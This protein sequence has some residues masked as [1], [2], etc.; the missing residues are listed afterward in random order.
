MLGEE[1]EVMSI[2]SIA[3]AERDRY[4]AYFDASLAEARSQNPESASELLIAINNE[5][6]PYPY[7]YLRVDLIG[8]LPDGSDRVY[9]LWLDPAPDAEGRGF[10][11]GPVKIEMY[12]FTWCS[13]QLAFDRPLPDM[14]KLE[15]LLTQLLDID[16]SRSNSGTALANA[17]HSVSQIETNGELW[18]LTIDFGTAPVD[19]LLDLIDFLMA[20]G[21]SRIIVASNPK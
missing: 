20:E 13:V 15:A 8:K 9:E 5:A 11:L 16:D 19:A 18:Y 4:V 10:D 14:A 17:I 7:R 12:P 2:V 21:M 3:T 6:M 1:G